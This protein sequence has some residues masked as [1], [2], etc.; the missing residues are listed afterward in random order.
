MAQAAR[1]ALLIGVGRAPETAGVLEP[2]E[3]PVGSDLRLLE[4]TLRASGYEVEVLPDAGRNQIRLAID[5][6]ARQ[7]PAD[8]TLLLYFSGHGLRVDGIDYLVPADAIAPSDGVW[9]ELH[10]DTLLPA[11]ISPLLRSCE[12]GTVLWFVDACRTE[13]EGDGVQFAN[14]AD[15]GPPQGGFAVM[16]G[17]SAG[18]YSGYTGEGSFFTKG[19]AEALGPM[20]PARTVEDVLAAARAATIKS[21]RRHRVQQTP[22]FRYGTY[23]EDRTRKTEICE[24]RA[25]LEAWQGAVRETPLWEHVP[26][27]ERDVLVGVLEEF[28]EDSARVVHRAQERWEEADPWVDDAFPVRVLRDRLPELLPPGLALSAVEVVALV[29]APFLHEVA[30]AERVS[31]AVEVGP[32]DVERRG[33]SAHRL[34]YEQ[35]VEQHGRIARKLADC[36]ARG[37]VEDVA[38]LTMWL[39][40]RWIADRFE[41]D[42]EVV[43]VGPAVGLAERLGLVADRA[44]DLGESLRAVASGVG[45]E[46]TVE[47][48]GPR[49]VLV[50][51]KGHQELR[52]GELGALLR[53][54]SLLAVDVRVL[55]DV[56]ADHLAVSDA[57][58]P[59]QVVGVARELSWHRE[60]SALHLD[61][62]CPHQAVHAALAEVV[63]EADRVA[64]RISGGGVLLAEVPG[65]VTDR[66]LRPSRVGGR[67][68][69]EVP[70]LRFHLAQTEVR[71]LLMGEQLYGGEPELALRE[72]YQNAMDACRYRGMRWRYLESS[73]AHPVEW[74]GRI[75]FSQGED[76]RGRY[77]ECRDNGVG[78]SREQLKQT[79][80]RAGSRFERSSS[81]RREQ[82]KWLRHDPSLRLYPNSRFGI[83]VFSY[84]MLADEMSI[85]TRQVSPKGIPAEHALRVDIPSSGSLF[86]VQRHDG[87]DDGVAEGGT[88]VRLYLREDERIRDLSC[89]RVLQELVWVSEFR[90][91]ARDLG[92]VENV[93]SPGVLQAGALPSLEAVPGEL[94]WVDGGGAIL[95]DG[96]ATDQEPFGYVVNL[97]GARAGKLS[98][99]RKEL[100]GYDAGWVK[101]LW[102]RGAGVLPGSALLSLRWIWR[103]DQR[104]PALARVLG[105]EWRG[106]GVQVDVPGRKPRSLDQVG[107]FHRDDA[108]ITN[109]NL[110]TGHDTYLPW[111]VKVFGMSRQFQDMA[112]PASLDG[113]PVPLPGDAEL[114]QNAPVSWHRVLHRATA[115]EAHPEQV[116]R[117]LRELR[118]AHVHYAPLPHR[119]ETVPQASESYALFRLFDPS[120]GTMTQVAGGDGTLHWGSLLALSVRSAL[121]LGELVRQ[122]TPFQPLLPSPLPVVPEHLQDRVCTD[123][124]LQRIFLRSGRS[125]WALPTTLM[126]LEQV[127]QNT[128]ASVPEVHHALAEFSWLGWTVPLTEVVR[129]WPSL[130]EDLRDVVGI[131]VREDLLPWAAT[132]DFADTLGT[133]LYTAEEQLA[134]AATD[135]GLLHERRCT[136]ATDARPS[137]DAAILVRQLASLGVLLEDGV[138][139]ESLHLACDEDSDIVDLDLAVDDL[140]SVG[141][142]LPDNIA[143]VL[144]WDTLP[145]HDRYILSG[146]EASLIENDYPAYA[147]TSAVLFN[148]AN[149]LNETLSDV[150]ATA[151]TYTER[152]EFTLPHLPASL[153]DC[154]PTGHMTTALLDHLDNPN[155]TLGTPVWKPLRPHDLATYARRRATTPATAHAELLPLRELGALIPNLTPTQLAALPTQVPTQHDLLALSD[156]H[157]VTPPTSPHTPLDLLSIAARLGEPLPRTAARITPYLPLTETPTPLPD[158][159][160]LI[161]LWQDLAILSR[162]LDGLLPALEGQVTQDHITRA[163]EA[164]GMTEPWVRDRLSQ[165]AGMFSLTL[166]QKT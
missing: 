106:E 126:G 18:E 21:A 38:A 118:I 15:S 78:M 49:R 93:W 136:S 119:G 27:G 120:S 123:S 31:Q 58:L 51:G 143:I 22:W 12:A 42:D 5:G 17:C 75:V 135:L 48:W 71:E 115:Q 43:P 7:V 16:A 145:L 137:T 160:D 67:E 90:V 105:S 56:V 73:G 131:F 161:P 128:G 34:H 80:T 129:R 109:S 60:G 14:Q 132:V 41:T 19:L 54:A 37:R 8:G 97:S 158:P 165:Y 13:L 88:R 139:A 1:R 26:A 85:V 95:C 86:R 155:Q 134:Q 82:S 150:W 107:W 23:E 3:E 112:A 162:H 66:E 29:A 25:L 53:L 40:H 65:R 4:A 87:A 101:E 89:V 20:T 148:A 152:F 99:N 116:Q 62:L 68:S 44:Q 154:H 64:G 70:L 94:W 76:E 166:D 100:Q 108:L 117:R 46:E 84:F 69:Y 110:S 147:V 157:R 61:A 35:V 164:T 156:S 81:F 127:A 83:G 104:S 52:V 144:E 28:A 33:G 102:R 6:T 96:I 114:V 24:G 32:Y 133:D 141:V 121:P 2:L 50:P 11:N 146:K 30:W 140:R 98:V 63:E 111:R 47:G 39:V 57:V 36:R 142:R 103:L 10:L 72:L 74:N 113:Y 138:T 149:R 125:G 9:S 45:A 122:L 151:D 163:A 92:G 124:D 79:F 159:P 77:V 130:D 91:E 59:Q 55:P 153:G